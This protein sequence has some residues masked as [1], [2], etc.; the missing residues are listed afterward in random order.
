MLRVRDDGHGSTSPKSNLGIQWN[1]ATGCRLFS[2]CSSRSHTK[3]S[4]CIWNL[5]QGRTV[6]DRYGYSCRRPRQTSIVRAV[7]ARR[8]L[9]ARQELPIYGWHI[10]GDCRFSHR[11]RDV[12][13]VV[14]HARRS[15]RHD[16][17]RR[18]HEQGPI[19][20]SG[21]RESPRV[22]KE[23]LPGRKRLQLA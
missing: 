8:G 23:K 15:H 12:G 16:R 11:H 2:C 1:R 17:V 10:D 6:C 3:G 21:I 7:R 18:P 19:R 4:S 20:P 5:R 13:K 9:D 14:R 22:G